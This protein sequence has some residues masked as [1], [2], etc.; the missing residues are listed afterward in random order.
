MF[1]VLSYWFPQEAGVGVGFE[2]GFE[3]VPV[4]G[5][6]KRENNMLTVE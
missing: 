3:A 4:P 2:A 5:K 6:Q 1:W